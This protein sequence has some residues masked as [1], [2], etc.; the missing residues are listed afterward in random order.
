MKT[1]T[2][3]LSN[4]FWSWREYLRVRLD[5]YRRFYNPP[6]QPKPLDVNVWI[7]WQSGTYDSKLFVDSVPRIHCVI[8]NDEDGSGLMDVVTDVL[9]VLDSPST[10]K[11]RFAFY[12]KTSGD[13]LGD[14]WIRDTLV[15]LETVYDTGITSKMIM[16][17]T[18]VKTARSMK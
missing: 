14:I 17:H 18:Q 13:Q 16:I 12:D 9:N 5:G 7:I 8:R 2:R 3:Y 10:G 11:R 4:I 1:E 6:S 15:G